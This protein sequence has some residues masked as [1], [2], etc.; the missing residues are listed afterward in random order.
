VTF[1]LLNESV[2]LDTKRVDTDTTEIGN[3]TLEGNF[4]NAALDPEDTLKVRADATDGDTG[5]TVENTI[6]TTDARPG[7]NVTAV[8]KLL[9]D[10]VSFTSTPSSPEINQEITLDASDSSDDSGIDTYEWDLNDDGTFE[11]S[12]QT[13]TTSFDSPGDYTITLRVTDTNGASSTAEETLRVSKTA[14]QQIK[15]AHLETAQTVDDATID[16]VQQGVSGIGVTSEAQAANDAYTEAVENGDISE[17]TA[18]SALRRLDRGI[19]LTGTVAKRIGPQP[20]GTNDTNDVDLTQSM[21]APTIRTVVNLAAGISSMGKAADSADDIG[22]IKGEIIETAKEQVI[23]GINSVIKYVLGESSDIAGTVKTEGNKIAEDLLNNGF[24]TAAE[25]NDVIDTVTSR[26]V[27]S[28]SVALQTYVEQGNALGTPEVPQLTGT[29]FE[30]SPLTL[31]GGATLMYEALSADRVS[32]NGL[33][34]ST[35]TAASAA[36]TARQNIK[37]V[38]G[39]AQSNI[40]AISGVAD[41]FNI[42]ESLVSLIQ[43]P[44]IFSGIK[45]VIS[46]IT[47]LLGSFIDAL[48]TGAGIGGLIEINIRHHVGLYSIIQG[49]TV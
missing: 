37:D 14:F 4:S 28:A 16:T 32:S 15:E 42:G 35:T 43:D 12:G 2:E 36:S 38:A 49:E 26:I 47:S 1:T 45:T 9:L 29:V 41:E 31:D 30:D 44:D 11:A 23:N 5:Y 20:E 13:T 48:A 46:V 21:A 25:V 3:V 34:G 22:L 10:S 18:V 6:A 39:S 40:E 27:E 24:E 8:D 19:G 33:V 7:G 17:D